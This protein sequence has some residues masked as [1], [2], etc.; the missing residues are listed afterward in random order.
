MA[1]SFFLFAPVEPLSPGFAYRLDDRLRKANTERRDLLV[2][3]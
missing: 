3:P 2:L 1:L